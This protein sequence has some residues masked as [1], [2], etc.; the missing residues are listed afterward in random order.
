MNNKFC[1][2]DIVWDPRLNKMLTVEKVRFSKVFSTY[3]YSFED[4]PYEVK[5]EKLENS[6]KIL[7]ERLDNILIQLNKNGS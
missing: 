4:Y 5:E 7:L 6:S 2:G 1:K 3:I